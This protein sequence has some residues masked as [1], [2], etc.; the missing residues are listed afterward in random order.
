M[1]KRNTIIHCFVLIQIM[2]MMN[3]ELTVK[4]H[5]G[6]EFM[7]SM[8][9]NYA[10]S[11]ITI[12][13]ASDSSGSLQLYVPYLNMN[14]TET[15]RVGHTTLS[16][17]KSIVKKGNFSEERAIQ[18]KTNVPVAIFVTS[19]L[20]S[21]P[22]TFLALPT[23]SLGKK[24]VIAS[25][26]PERGFISATAIV[27]SFPNTTINTNH[28]GLV[29]LDKF[30]VL[31]TQSRSDQ[32]GMVVSATK[33]VS[34]ISGTSCSNI[35]AG[36]NDCDNIIEQ[37]IPVSMW[38]NIYIIP[39][40]P[41]KSGYL[42][43]I[44]TLDSLYMCVQNSTKK[45]CQHMVQNSYKEFRL[46]SEPTVVYTNDSST[47]SVTQYGMSQSIDDIDSG[48][49]MT[50]IPGIQNFL[51]KYNFVV[52]PVYSSFRNYVTVIIKKS[53]VSG[54][55]LDGRAFQAAYNYTVSRPL[56]HYVVLVTTISTGYHIL[57]NSDPTAEFGAFMYGYWAIAGYGTPLG[58][59]FKDET[60]IS[61]PN[62]LRCYHC[63]EMSSLEVCDAV[64]TCSDAQICFAEKYASRTGYFYKSGCMPKEQCQN[65][66]SSS[67]VCL[68]CCHGN[69][70]NNKGCGD[71]RFPD[72]QNRGP[73]CYDCQHILNDTDLCMKVTMCGPDEVCSI[74][75]YRWGN[76]FHYKMGCT[77][78]LC[79]PMRRSSVP[80][81]LRRST[82][83]C[84]ACC[85]DDFCNGNCTQTTNNPTGQI[86]IGKNYSFS[87]SVL[88][89][90]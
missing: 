27:S 76:D 21:S 14:R 81:R 46:G 90:K 55:R 35:P 67:G 85:T 78:K 80:R 2:C 41:P 5:Y 50:V 24:Y 63:D 22:D 25:Y 79:T 7:F 54:L 16:I 47:F 31:Q 12:D 8:T 60:K 30:Y 70:C 23:N 37:M 6:T 58:F 44:Q 38:T 28:Q 3:C 64:K 9:P 18:I 15:L 33:P 73:M 88:E 36:V 89:H 84:S 74:E 40:L 82:P 43:R 11:N 75:K 19:F 83:V 65:T 86:I 1:M 29:T 69:Y 20:S 34:V 87:I 61:P 56:D 68:E 57:N 32:T 10:E 62:K 72:R 51:T 48:P 49:F 26:Q 13:I 39:P 53:D 4:S 71:D 77:H 59:S 17:S 52:P 45:S 42:A 66:T